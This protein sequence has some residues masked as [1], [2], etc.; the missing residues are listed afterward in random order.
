MRWGGKE[1]FFSEKKSVSA[2]M[3]AWADVS[4]SRCLK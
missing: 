4:L 1:Y 2:R 3:A